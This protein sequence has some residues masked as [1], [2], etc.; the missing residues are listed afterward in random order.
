M[1][2]IIFCPRNTRK[3]EEHFKICVI[4][5]DFF[6][7]FVGKVRGFFKTDNS[8]NKIDHRKMWMATKLIELNHSR[9]RTGIFLENL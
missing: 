7:C 9:S 6:V 4:F 3:K 8:G 1:K 2:L 5:F